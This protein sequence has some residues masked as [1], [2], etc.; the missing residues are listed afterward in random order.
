[1][2]LEKMPSYAWIP[3]TDLEIK[4]SED[5]VGTPY[6]LQPVLGAGGRAGTGRSWMLSGKYVPLTSSATRNPQ[7]QMLTVG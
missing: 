2:S 3:R 4:S 7:E 5:T 6:S 1:M